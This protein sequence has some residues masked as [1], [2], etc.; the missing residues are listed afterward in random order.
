MRR[1]TMTDSATATNT[2]SV[3]TETSCTRIEIGNKPANVATDSPH[4]TVPQ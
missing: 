1:R 4:I 3:P 2:M